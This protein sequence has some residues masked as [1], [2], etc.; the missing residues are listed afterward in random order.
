M[1]ETLPK[2]GVENDERAK[3]VID[4]LRR[5]GPRSVLRGVNLTVRHGE[6]LVLLGLSGSG[7]TTLFRHLM[8]SLLPESG[9]IHLDGQSMADFHYKIGNNF[10]G[11]P[12][13]SFNTPP[14][15]VH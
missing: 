9:S 11:K 3:I 12:A 6:T 7:K 10:V 8:G 15:W 1:T 13:S 4:D 14:C 5:S 2:K